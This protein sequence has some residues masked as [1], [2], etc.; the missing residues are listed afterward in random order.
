M[1]DDECGSVGG[2]NGRV[3]R[4][5]RR[6]PTPLPFCPPHISYGV[7][8]PRSWAAAVDGSHLAL[9]KLILVACS[10][11]GFGVYRLTWQRRMFQAYSPVGVGAYRLTW[12]RRMSQARSPV[13]VGAYR[14]TWQRRMFQACSPVGVDV[15]YPTWPRRMPHICPC[16]LEPKTFRESS[17]KKASDVYGGVSPLAS[18]RPRRRVGE[19]ND[20]STPSYCGSDW[21]CSDAVMKQIWTAR[22]NPKFHIV[23]VFSHR[24]C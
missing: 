21:R 22:R 24:S 13:G 3:N 16:N 10:P 2:M 9:M 11:V 15:Y 20:S 23:T 4:S 5:T 7:L 8:C 14:L 19:V 6:K 12:Q 18:N 1:P 17:V